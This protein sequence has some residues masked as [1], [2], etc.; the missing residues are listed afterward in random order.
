MSE[1][2]TPTHTPTHS[3]R[4]KGVSW[5][6][7]NE[8]L[9][10][11]LHSEPANE[12]GTTSL[13]ELE[14][15]AAYLKDGGGGAKALIIHSDRDRGFCAGADLRELYQGIVDRTQ[16]GMTKADTA[17]EVL[18]F[19]ERIH[20]VFDT[21]DMAPLTTIA[22]VS[23]VCFG[24]GLELMLTCDVVVADKSARFAFPE[25]RLGL[26]PGFG[27]I[28]R[29]RRDVGNAAIRDL[30]MTGRS[31]N[32]KRAHELGLISQVVARGE[33]LRAARSLA[34][35]ACRFDARTTQVAKRF[36][37]PLPSDELREERALFCEL[38]QSPHVEAA[39]QRFVQSQAPMPYLP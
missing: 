25:L 2:P 27:G 39:L 16:S 20:G 21:L 8:V 37:K 4:G 6:L 10:V 18:Q 30:L 1:A 15:L 32:A 29:L 14:T 13:G 36:I 31:L 24:G 19:L 9:E 28:P 5:T 12:L 26:I 33:A 35:Q 34:K 22:A 11:L 23:G 38:F 17:T 3:H 7:S